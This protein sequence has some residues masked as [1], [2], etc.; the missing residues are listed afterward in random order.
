MAKDLEVASAIGSPV[1]TLLRTQVPA[2]EATFQR[3]LIEEENE[4]GAF[5]AV[6]VFADWLANRLGESPEAV[7][8][9]RG[10][11]VI[12]DVAGS[13]YPLGRELVRE[14]VEALADDPEAVN[15]MGPETRVR[16]T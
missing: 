8:V 6:S 15:R 1:V 10:F 7:E 5:Q 11:Q 13:D 12:E 14:F 2:F 4:M 3:L 9:R 16:L